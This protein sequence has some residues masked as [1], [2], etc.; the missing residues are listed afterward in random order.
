MERRAHATSHAEAL[1][2]DRDAAY[3]HSRVVPVSPHTHISGEGTSRMKR[4]LDVWGSA[5]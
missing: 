5:R 2:P 4:S 1:R 3:E